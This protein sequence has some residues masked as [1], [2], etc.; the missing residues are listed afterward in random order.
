MLS[1]AG[2]QRAS[3]RPERRRLR[4][5]AADDRRR[6]TVLAGGRLGPR[7]A[8]WPL[9][10]AGAALGALRR[11]RLVPR[12]PRGRRDLDRRTG[13]SSGRSAPRTWLATRR[14]TSDSGRGEPSRGIGA[15]R[16]RSPPAASARK[17]H[18]EARRDAPG[19]R[20]SA[21]RRSVQRAG[22]ARRAGRRG[23]PR[24]HSD[25]RARHGDTS[26]WPLPSHD[27]AAPRRH[28]RS[29]A[30]RARRRSPTIACASPIPAASPSRWTIRTATAGC[31]PTSTCICSAKASTPASTTSS[32]RTR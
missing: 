12:L 23:D 16:P 6:R 25:R 4:A 32:A 22:S 24:G 26:G 10:L 11:D 27:A 17:R 19:A 3:R 7:R 1:Q 21:P 15:L 30:A 31:S 8:R 13:R 9:R 14:R 20:R 28:L 18:D 2:A 5:R 29:D